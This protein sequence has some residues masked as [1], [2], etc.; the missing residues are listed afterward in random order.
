MPQLFPRGIVSRTSVH[1]EA[2]T[3]NSQLAQRKLAQR[4]L[5]LRKAAERSVFPTSC[6]AVIEN[7][8]S[9]ELLSASY[10]VAPWGSDNNTG[11]LAAPFKTIERAATVASPGDFVEIETGVYHETVT[12]KHSGTPGAHYLRSIQ[13]RSRHHQR[14]RC[15][16]RLVQIQQHHLQNLARL[17]SGRRQ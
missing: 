14:R 12:P 15:R 13:P 5:T 16:R 9:R 1:A 6:L 7:L 8:E 17:G 11:N 10:F 4:Q 3:S 2:R